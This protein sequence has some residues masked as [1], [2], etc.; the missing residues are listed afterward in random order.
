MGKPE[1]LPESVCPV[2]GKEVKVG[3]GKFACKSCGAVGEIKASVTVE[4]HPFFDDS[5]PETEP[6][7]VIKKNPWGVGGHHGDGSRWEEI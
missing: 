7:L 4:P 5:E 6:V 2:C 3:K 1:K